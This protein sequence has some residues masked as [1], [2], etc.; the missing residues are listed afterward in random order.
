MI[1]QPTSENSKV[2]KPDIGNSNESDI[3]NSDLDGKTNE[4][5]KPFSQENGLKSAE[6]VFKNEGDEAK[7]SSLDED[8]EFLKYLRFRNRAKELGLDDPS[9]TT[10]YQ[11]GIHIKDSNVENHGNVVGNNQTTHSNSKTG[12]FS[13]EVLEKSLDNNKT[14]ESIESVFDECDNIKQRSFMIALAALNGCNYRIVVEASQR[15]QSILQPQEE[16]E[17]EA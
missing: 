14:I 11:G 10:I 1:D 15:L 3:S 6:K 13:G 17:A 9:L 2:N 7:N 16:M 5:V 8:T 4:S 12:G